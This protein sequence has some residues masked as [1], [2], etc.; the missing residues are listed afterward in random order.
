VI[1]TSWLLIRK[2]ASCFK[3]IAEKYVSE[4]ESTNPE[5]RDGSGK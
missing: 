3:F 4:I 5:I 2:A 1:E